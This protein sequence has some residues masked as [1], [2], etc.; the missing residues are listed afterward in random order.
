MTTPGVHKGMAVETKSQQR[1]MATLAVAL[2]LLFAATI[3]SFT[4]AKT[5]MMEQ[6]ISANEV[7]A[8]EAAF[9]AEAALEYGIFQ[10]LNSGICNPTDTITFSAAEPA[11]QDYSVAL[12]CVVTTHPEATTNVDFYRLTATAARGSYS[13]GGNANPDFVSRKIRATVSTEPP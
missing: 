10:A 3:L 2:V 8:R 9:A 12:T 1:G 6:R 4:V 5:G 7:R 11:L 13:L